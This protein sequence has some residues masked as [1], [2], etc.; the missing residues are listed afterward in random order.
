MAVL[1]PNTLSPPL[2]SSNAGFG[3][4]VVALKAG[5]FELVA[6]DD[7][8]SG[9]S[10]WGPFGISFLCRSLE[11]RRL[12]DASAET[13]ASLRSDTPDFVSRVFE[14]DKVGAHGAASDFTIPLPARKMREGF[15]SLGPTK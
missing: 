15:I 11:V 8:I 13:A 10:R 3:A 14:A 5:R 12:L 2:R 1:A 6:A 7:E 4:V 9:C